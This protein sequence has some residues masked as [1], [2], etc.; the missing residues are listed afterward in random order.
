[1]DL[2]ALARTEAMRT[3][4]GM[5]IYEYEPGFN[6]F[7]DPGAAD[8]AEMS[9]YSMIEALAR[10]VFGG[11]EFMKRGI[12]ALV[13]A[14]IVAALVKHALDA[15]SD[16]LFGDVVGVVVRVVFVEEEDVDDDEGGADG[17]GGIGDVEGRPVVA[18]EPNFEEV[19]DGAMDDAIGYVS[20]C[21]AKQ[22]REA[23]SS[24]GSAAVAGDEQPSERADHRSRA[25][26][27]QDAHRGGWRIGEDAEGD[28]GI[29]AVH[30]I[31][32]IVNQ[33]AVPAFDGS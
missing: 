10:I 25:D 16:L 11:D 6:E 22:K 32:E 14:E 27:Q 12:V 2:N 1:L 18:A 13:H 7:L 3:L 26:D 20:G 19:D 4:G 24:E 8:V 29:A 31:D 9:G 21:T 30:Q 5:G 33:L 28:T 15:V 23:G 17:D